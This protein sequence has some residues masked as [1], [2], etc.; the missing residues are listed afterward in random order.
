V[1]PPALA[2]KPKMKNMSDKITLFDIDE[3]ELARQLTY[4]T[5][6]LYSKIEVSW[7]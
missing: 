2:G 5:W 4:R 3:L 6:A 7:C 1:T